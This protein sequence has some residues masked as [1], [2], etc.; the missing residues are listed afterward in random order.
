MQYNKETIELK[1]MIFQCAADL[2][3]TVKPRQEVADTLLRC[4][5]II[6]GCNQGGKL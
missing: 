1:Q 2:Y 3:L 6:N 4:L 5:S